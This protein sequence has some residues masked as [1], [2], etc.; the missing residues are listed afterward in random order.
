MLSSRTTRRIYK[1][2]YIRAFGKKAPQ[3]VVCIN[4]RWKQYYR[5]S[6]SEDWWISAQG[7]IYWQSKLKPHF[8]KIEKSLSRYWPSMCSF[9]EN[10][11]RWKIFCIPSCKLYIDV[12][13]TYK[14]VMNIEPCFQQIVVSQRGTC[15]FSS[16]TFQCS[17]YY[18]F[19]SLSIVCRIEMNIL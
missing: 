6:L 3:K 14:Q 9:Y 2:G 15:F 18:F 16:L 4:L 5:Y 13:S 11:L 7:K 10:S 8:V 12:I 19:I 1:R 17:C